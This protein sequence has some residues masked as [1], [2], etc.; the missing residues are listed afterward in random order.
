MGIIGDLFDLLE[1]LIVTIPVDNALSG[2]YVILNLILGI[3]AVILGGETGN[4]LPF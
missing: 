4:F 3:V 1:S 2:A